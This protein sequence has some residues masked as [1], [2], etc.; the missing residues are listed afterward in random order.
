MGADAL[1]AARS[2][3]TPRRPTRPTRS[4]S[5]EE[6]AAECAAIDVALFVEPLSF[7]LDL[8]SRS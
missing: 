4:G 1:E 3:T 2:T 6:V 7:S 5:L 8:P